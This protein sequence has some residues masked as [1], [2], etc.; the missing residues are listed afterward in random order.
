MRDEKGIVVVV[1]TSCVVYVLLAI[2]MCGFFSFENAPVQT[3]RKVEVL[4][5]PQWKSRS[6]GFYVS[7]RRKV[8]GLL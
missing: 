2:R 1:F 7:E 4:T 8:P 3:H 6:G 5:Q